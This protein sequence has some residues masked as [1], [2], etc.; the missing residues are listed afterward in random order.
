[1]RE[2]QHCRV[3]REHR[4]LTITIDRPEVLNALHPPAHR[5]L[6]HA[7]DLCAGDSELRVAI[8]TAAGERAFCVGS[9]INVRAE[10]G[11]DDHPD[12]GFAGIT[13]RFDL[14]K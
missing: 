1:M 8:L 7:F 14:L 9:D 11:R 12:T 13:R 6:A 2:F 10:T 5:E 4:V 3:E